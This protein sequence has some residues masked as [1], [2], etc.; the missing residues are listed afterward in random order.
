MKKSLIAAA[1]FAVATLGVTPASAKP[2]PA[3]LAVVGPFAVGSPDADTMEAEL[4]EFTSA[5]RVEVTYEEH[6]GPGDLE[7]RV[8]G[9]TRRI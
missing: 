3:S 4:A 7:D 9:S 8:T 1:L 5:N 6:F 2:V